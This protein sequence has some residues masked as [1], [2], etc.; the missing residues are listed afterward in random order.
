MDFIVKLLFLGGKYISQAAGRTILEIYNRSVKLGRHMSVQYEKTSEI[1][2]PYDNMLEL[3][4]ERVK[5]NSDDDVHLAYI[6]DELKKQLEDHLKR[7]PKIKSEEINELAS[8]NSISS[9]SSWRD[10]DSTLTLAEDVHED[11]F[12]AGENGLVSKDFEYDKMYTD[13]CKDLSNVIVKNTSVDCPIDHIAM[14]TKHNIAFKTSQTNEVL[15][16]YNYLASHGTSIIDHKFAAS[17][18][19]E[20]T[21]SSENLKSNSR[22]FMEPISQPFHFEYFNRYRKSCRCNPL[23]SLYKADPSYMK[24]LVDRLPSDSYYKAKAIGNNGVDAAVMPTT[25]EQNRCN[26]ANADEIIQMNNKEIIK[27]LVEEIENRM[28]LLKKNNEHF[29]TFEKKL[30]DRIVKSKVQQI[31]KDV[32][33]RS[34]ILSQNTIHYNKFENKLEKKLKGVVN[35][36]VTHRTLSSG[37]VGSSKHDLDEGIREIIDLLKVNEKEFQKLEQKVTQRLIRNGLNNDN[38]ANLKE[39]KSF[40]QKRCLS[41]YDEADRKERA[42]ILEIN[43]RVFEKFEKDMRS[44]VIL[45]KNKPMDKDDKLISERLAKYHV[46]VHNDGTFNEVLNM[47]RLQFND[48]PFTKLKTKTTKRKEKKTF[49]HC[50]SM[51]NTMED[52]RERANIIQANAKAFEL[53]ESKMNNLTQTNLPKFLTSNTFNG[54]NRDSDKKS[55]GAKIANEFDSTQIINTLKEVLD[56]STI[57]KAPKSNSRINRDIKAINE[58]NFDLTSNLGKIEKVLSGK[59]VQTQRGIGVMHEKPKEIRQICERKKDEPLSR[60]PKKFECS[61]KNVDG[62]KDQKL[63][64]NSKKHNKK[65]TDPQFKPDIKNDDEND[66]SFLVTMQRLQE[67]TAQ[68]RKKLSKNASHKSGKPN[69]N[70]DC[71]SAEAYEQNTNDNQNKVKSPQLCEKGKPNSSE[72]STANLKGFQGS[73]IPKF[74]DQATSGSPKRDNAMDLKRTKSEGSSN[75]FDNESVRVAA[76][77]RNENPIKIEETE[78]QSTCELGNTDRKLNSSVRHD[79][80]GK[81]PFKDQAKLSKVNMSHVKESALPRHGKQRDDN[82]TKTSTLS[83]TDQATQKP[84]LDRKEGI[85]EF[86][87]KHS[88]DVDFDK[89]IGKSKTDKATINKERPSNQTERSKKNYVTACKVPR[90]NESKLPQPNSNTFNCAKDN[91]GKSMFKKCY[92]EKTKV[93]EK[94]STPKSMQTKN[95]EIGK[96]AQKDITSSNEVKNFPNERQQSLDLEKKYYDK[97]KPTA[98]FSIPSKARE[99]DALIKKEKHESKKIFEQDSLRNPQAA[100]K[101]KNIEIPKEG[102]LIDKAK[103]CEEK[104]EINQKNSTGNLNKTNQNVNVA[105]KSKTPKKLVR[106]ST[107]STNPST[108]KIKGKQIVDNDGKPATKAKI[109]SPTASH[110]FP[111]TSHDFP[112]SHLKKKIESSSKSLKVAKNEPEKEVEYSGKCNA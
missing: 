7:V 37:N 62:K 9:Q 19:D 108:F 101:L 38:L 58:V 51:E 80:D 65:P 77:K 10:N 103:A 64:G 21:T 90:E 98:S 105:N 111:T 56:N 24:Y 36:L 88:N 86:T 16:S 75:M 27:G 40:M 102:I 74:Y 26:Y 6:N 84:E 73:R 8:D 81:V 47:E 109:N 45:E 82:N 42:K 31:S 15:E 66:E 53:F 41:N 91:D 63:E 92:N 28:V 99:Q 61:E 71:K 89:R 97:S 33:L 32:K 79:K 106:N 87:S 110:N 57:F 107:P 69:A 43:K 55:K 46:K 4:N 20:K 13:L 68:Y 30:H 50:P 104:H 112:T 12:T 100:T 83:S 76:N 94:V 95:Q 96:G 2:K 49:R 23:S 34:S 1:I 29:K 17:S 85:V 39:R 35:N 59:E 44:I 11:T 3:L 60:I 14:S 18:G 5:E 78:D 25:K 52:I 22:E 72:I 54:N 48:F 70:M 93:G 67:M